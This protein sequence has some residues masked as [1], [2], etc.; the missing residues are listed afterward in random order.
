MRIPNGFVIKIT[1]V[2]IT[3]THLI[4]KMDLFDVKWLNSREKVDTKIIEDHQKW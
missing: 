3:I 2:I 4:K 1:Q